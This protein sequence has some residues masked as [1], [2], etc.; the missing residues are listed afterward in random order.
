MK[1]VFILAMCQKQEDHAEK[2]GFLSISHPGCSTLPQPQ[3]KEGPSHSLSQTHCSPCVPKVA[4]HKKYTDPAILPQMAP[5]S[6][7]LY[8]F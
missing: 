5:V 7:L 8:L 4:M 6:L 2:T 1:V 3:P